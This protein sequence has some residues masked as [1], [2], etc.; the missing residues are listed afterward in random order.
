MCQ[1]Y[2]CEV[3][4]IQLMEDAATRRAYEAATRGEPKVNTYRQN[5]YEH[6]AYEHGYACFE[7]GVLPWCIER[8]QRK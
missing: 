7:S 8:E 5:S 3:R 4:L 1:A 6:K 2:E